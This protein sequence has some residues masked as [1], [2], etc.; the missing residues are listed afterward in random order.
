MSLSLLT[1]DHLDR[2]AIEVEKGFLT[3]GE[4][5][6]LGTELDLP[7]SQVVVAEAMIRE[8][9]DF[10]LV[11]E[12][13]FAAFAHNMRALEKGTKDGNS[14]V[15]GTVAS[16][17]AKQDVGVLIGD[18]LIDRA[19]VYTLAT[20]VG[21]HEVGLSPCAGTGDSCPYTGL[22]KALMETGVDLP[23]VK[24]TAALILKVG[25]IYR[26]GKATTGCNMEGYGAGSPA[27]AAALTDLRGGTAEQVGKAMVLAI[28]PTLAVPCTPRVITRGLCGAHIGS[29][30]LIGNL[31]SNLILKS[32]IPV[33]IDVDVM[34][35]M[36]A[37]IHREA[38]PVITAV[39][40]KYMRPYFSKRPQ[41]EALL[42]K[43]QA[44]GQDDPSNIILAEAREE[45]HAMLES[46]RPL[47]RTMGEIVV[48][49]SSIAVGSPTNMARIAHAL[50][51]GS[52]KQ[53]DIELTKD[54]YNRR[55]INVPAIL[56]GAM[57][58]SHTSDGDMYGKVMDLPA[59]KNINITLSEIEEPEVQRIR[60]TT[61]Q[62]SVW[63]DSRNR[64][65]ARVAI[66]DCN[67]SIEAALAAAKDLGI[68]V[69]S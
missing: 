67:P 31:A 35:A 7:I 21:N 8:D 27:T 6:A 58:G 18:E 68:Q 62:G 22:L 1:Q 45:L 15:L 37:R 56:M 10:D 40:V 24:L 11:T 60:L 17:L 69:V 47:T 20:E 29:A 66:V 14:F 4:L 64:G 49:G 50:K 65:G 3:I 44:V 33:D 61:D 30:I 48:G 51:K 53:V 32:T 54:L 39:N 43:E 57:F 16:D 41:V 23:R 42:S 12:E 28:S 26:A 34:I 19:L 59:I 52:I 5:I 38:A 46:S 9:K 55:S 25:S 2:V 36:A 13:C 63:I